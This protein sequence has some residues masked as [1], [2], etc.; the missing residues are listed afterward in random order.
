M[1]KL[2]ADEARN[3]A[4]G[5]TEIIAVNPVASPPAIQGQEDGDA[6]LPHLIELFDRML[7]DQ[8]FDAVIIACFDDTGLW[9][10]KGRS[11]VPVI[12]IGEASFHAAMLFGRSFSIVTTLPVSVPVI[13]QNIVSQGITGRCAQV[14]ATNIPVLELEANPEASVARIS[15]EIEAAISAGNC[16]AIVLGCAGMADIT[17]T[18]QARFDVPIVDGVKAAVGLCETLHKLRAS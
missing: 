3:A 2:I 17:E 4:F 12:G 11:N 13:E 6:A 7:A 10:L 16:D 1:T 9:Q 15:E 14:R 5:E 18:L 8:E